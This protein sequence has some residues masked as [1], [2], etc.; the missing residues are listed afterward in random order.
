MKAGEDRNWVLNDQ[1]WNNKNLSNQ[2]TDKTN[3][4]NHNKN[5]K[6]NK[7]KTNCT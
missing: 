3:K 7:T 1:S 5:R 4:T 6:S 2:I